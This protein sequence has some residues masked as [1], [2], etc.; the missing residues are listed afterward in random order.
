[1]TTADARAARA[2][3][4]ILVIACAL[5][6]ALV[7]GLRA[8]GGRTAPP[9]PWLVTALLLLGVGL[10]G[11]ALVRGRQERLARAA[12][13]RHPDLPVALRAPAVR[14]G[15]GHGVAWDAPAARTAWR[16]LALRALLPLLGVALVAIALALPTRAYHDDD[17]LLTRDGV[18]VLGRVVGA[19]WAYEGRGGRPVATVTYTY[20]ER[21]CS[22]RVSGPVPA[23]T[24]P[25]ASL[26]LLVDP[27]RPS[28]VRADGRPG[29]S[30]GLEWWTS[31]CLGAAVALLAA[32]AARLA[33][34]A[35]WR[36]L[37]RRHPWVDAHLASVPGADRLALLTTPGLRSVVRARGMRSADSLPPS[38]DVRLLPGP[39]RELLVA[40][41]SGRLVPVVL[42]AHVAQGRRWMATLAAAEGASSPRTSTAART[43]EAAA[44]GVVAVPGEPG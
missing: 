41:P 11:L 21:T 37:M 39:G 30:A 3:A 14:G 27:S 5:G 15:G 18:R 25:G 42:P 17:A 44:T 19:G 12:L 7:V 26:P 36:A 6:Y 9:D 4:G 34:A 16:R 38:D 1:M 22:A 13:R 2:L 20:G 8:R 29:V 35:A 33:R 23:D 43:G 40:L 32:T 31:A 28:T 10:V 24:R